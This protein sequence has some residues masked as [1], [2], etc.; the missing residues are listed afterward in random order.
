MQFKKWDDIMAGVFDY[1]REVL[2]KEFVKNLTVNNVKISELI[3]R[4]GQ[5]VEMS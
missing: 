1:A 2:V 3:I 5:P 4:Y